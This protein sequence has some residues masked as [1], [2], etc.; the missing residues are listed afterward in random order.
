[1]APTSAV[2]RIGPRPQGRT[3]RSAPPSRARL[4][5][6]RRWTR[7]RR[8]PA[9]SAA[10]PR[11]CLLRPPPRRSGG[12]SR[13]RSALW[14]LVFPSRSGPGAGAALPGAQRRA[15]SSAAGYL[16]LLVRLDYVA[17][18]EILVVR[19]A[20][21][22]L[23]ALVHLA[24][25]FFEAPERSD[26]ALPQDDTVSEEPHLRTTADRA[27]GHIAA[28]DKADPRDPEHFANFRLSGHHLFELWSQHADDSGLDVFDQLVNDL[29]RP[30]L[31]SL[32]R[33]HR[34]C[35]AAGPHVEA[36]DRR[37][38]SRSEG[39]VVFGDPA[40]RTVH[41]RQLYVVALELA[42]AFGHRL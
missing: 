13:Q 25:V 36:D 39:N 1:M 38:R 26:R 40:H 17:G 10:T 18:P 27:V 8:R 11:G 23:E 41:E 6:G 5:R 24:H 14:Q 16:P 29:V 32:G 30:D 34:A 2:R 22:A 28:G 42:Q 21:A 7:R 12:G 15:R 9:R 4:L 3:I 33:C 20:H 37:V 19:Q 35:F 31:D